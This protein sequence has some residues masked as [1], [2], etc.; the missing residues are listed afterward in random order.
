MMRYL[1]G[2]YISTK[3]KHLGNLRMANRFGGV[4]VSDEE[5]SGGRFGGVPVS[6][7][8]YQYG[9]EEERTT[10]QDV[11]G[12][13]NK[14]VTLNPISGLV[15]A[16]NWGLK[17]VGAGSERPFL[18]T[19]HMNELFNSIGISTDAGDSIAG[20]IS[21]EVGA[22]LSG[23]A[24]LSAA[25]K[26]ADLGR[27]VAPMAEYYVTNPIKSLLFD[28]VGGTVSVAGG[29]AGEVAG[30]II[31]GEKGR[32]IGGNIGRMVAPAAVGGVVKAGQYAA[33]KADDFIPMT[34]DSKIRSA[35]RR[36]HEASSNTNPPN[37]IDVP[38]YGKAAT[39]E[40]FDDPGLIAARRAMDRSD[41][42]RIAYSQDRLSEQNQSLHEGLS[43]LN[44]SD[45]PGFTQSYVSRSVQKAIESK[46]SNIKR[47]TDR[48]IKAA[49][50]GPDADMD[51]I[52]LSARRD[53]DDAWKA[54]KGEERRLWKAIPS[55]SFYTGTV[56]EKANSM[57]DSLSKFDDPQDIHPLI[58]NMAGRKPPPHIM[59]EH[60]IT[61][62]KSKI[63][64]KFL[65]GDEPIDDLLKLRSR[66]LAAS[67][68]ESANGNWNRARITKEAAKSLMDDITPIGGGS[69]ALD[70][71]KDASHYTKDMHETFNRGPVGKIRGYTSDGDMRVSPEM[72]MERLLP[73]GT[74]GKIGA[75]ALIAAAEKSGNPEAARKS[76]EDFLSKK[77]VANH[78]NLDTGKV[79]L[80]TA[81]TFLKNNPVLDDFPSLK[82][83]ISSSRQAQALADQV[84]VS[85]GRR[86]KYLENISIA[87]RYTKGEPAAQ[88]DAVLNSPT[89]LKDM[90]VLTALA[91][92]DTSGR[93]MDGLKSSFYHAMKSRVAPDSKQMIDATGD[94]V[95]NANR[96]RTFLNK[97]KNVI[98]TLYGQKGVDVL[99][100]VSRGATL[101]ANISKG[102]AAGGGSDSTQNEQILQ[103][104]GTIG[105]VLGTKMSGGIHSLLAFGIGKRTTMS[106]AD[107]ISKNLVGR[108]DEI[109]HA[110]LYDPQLAQMIMTKPTEV[111]T[112]K[113]LNYAVSRGLIDEIPRAVEE[114]Q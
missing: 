111:N 2:R 105:G 108:V 42:S 63:Y 109:V 53:L 45:E 60:G 21:T 37:D 86:I 97:N 114:E 39:G 88:M 8:E 57:I 34:A 17:K 56:K 89:P 54:S 66:L 32:Q 31:G 12:G 27:Y 75:R 61:V 23:G 78:V 70:M 68:K 38:K 13:L 84:G 92:K 4:P 18:G 79:N 44:V 83:S 51:S 9:S 99:K 26:V 36:L 81:A 14:G 74:Q 50:I 16:V 67:R 65:S 1:Q 19:D 77:F 24:T 98:K 11:A 71:A 46:N 47:V 48:A 80:N 76:I 49:N 72:T 52:Q 10:S 28:T 29:E 69:K 30:E 91:K 55:E 6:P 94:A 41:S 33:S 58:Y 64:N 35:S 59:D 102:I 96:L 101:N 62:K 20:K 104:F 5:L 100:E 22:G 106:M 93:A 40:V 112:K 110:A 43:K 85:A 25:N 95:V 103:A 82:A 3:A 87:S 107:K 7:D 90:K 15:D 73:S 113:F